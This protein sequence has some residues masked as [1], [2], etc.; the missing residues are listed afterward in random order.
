MPR[1]AT[2]ILLNPDEKSQLLSLV[3]S[4]TLPPGLVQRAQ[5]VLACAEGEPGIA[6]AAAAAIEQEHR[7]QMAQTLSRVW[8]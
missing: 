5:I 7:G 6:I 3:Q 4:H 1:R 2:P 8:P